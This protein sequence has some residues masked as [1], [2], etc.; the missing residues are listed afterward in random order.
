MMRDEIVKV[1]NAVSQGI[2][3]ITNVAV[4]L[5]ALD[6]TQNRKQNLPGIAVFYGPSGFGKSMGAAYVGNRTNAYYVQATSVAT[7]KSFLQSVLREMGMP[8]VG[9]TNGLLDMVANELAKSGKPLIIDEADHLANG[10]RKIE[11]LRDIYEAS[12]GTLM[13]I[14]EE[15]LPRKLERYERFHGRVLQWA[16]AQ[17]ASLDDAKSL[18]D[19]YSP[20]LS[21]SDE[22]LSTLV[23]M[24]RGSTRRVCTNLE[25]LHEL[26]LV[27][28]VKQI[29]M[30]EYHA[31]MPKGFVTGESPKARKF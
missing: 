4:C 6:F 21:I 16:A 19:I 15:N 14:G 11:L 29:G 10:S 5:Q 25:Q 3:K 2:A 30:D 7:Q 28:G 27:R 13:I 24:V 22:V 26:A 23:G 31:L 12:Q 18:C 20:A 9:T 1:N 17:P 8:T